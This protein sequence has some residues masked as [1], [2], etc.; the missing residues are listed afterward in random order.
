MPDGDFR[1][2][3]RHSY[4]L[5]KWQILGEKLPDNDFTCGTPPPPD[6]GLS[7]ATRERPPFALP[8]FEIAGHA[9]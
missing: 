2:G 9:T 4:L 1:F 8:K 3:F 5:V 6:V 7:L